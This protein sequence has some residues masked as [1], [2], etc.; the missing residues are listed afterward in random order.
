[1]VSKINKM[2]FTINQSAWNP[3]FLFLYHKDDAVTRINHRQLCLMEGK[4]NVHP[5]SDCISVLDGT[6]RA[7]K[8]PWSFPHWDSYWMCDGLIYKYVLGNSRSIS[9]RSAIFIIEYDTWWNTQSIN[10]APSLLSQYDI[11]GAEVLINGRHGW[12]FFSKHSHLSFSKDLIGIRPF[13]SICCRPKALIKAA[14]FVRDTQEMHKVYN[15]EMRFA[16][17]CKLSGSRIGN[18]P[19][20]FS[21]SIKWN[22]WNPKCGSEECIVHPV[23]RSDQL[24]I[25]ALSNHNMVHKNVKDKKLP[26]PKM[27]KIDDLSVVTAA[28]YGSLQD[29]RNACNRLRA[30]V[31]HFGLELIEF[32]GDRPKSLQD[33]KIFKLK[34][35]LEK[36]NTKWTLFIDASDVICVQNPLRAVELLRRSNKEILMSAESVCWPEDHLKDRFAK[37]QHK[38][39]E[40]YRFLNSGVFIGKT[41]HIIKHL[42]K[43]IKMISKNPS[44]NETW[45]TDQNIWQYLFLDQ[46]KNGSSISLDLDAN[47]SLSTYSIGD[48]MIVDSSRNGVK[49]PKFS[50]TGGKPLFLHFNGNDKHD[51][52]RISRHISRWLPNCQQSLIP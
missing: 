51:A 4:D 20:K 10:W 11:C 48:D 30:T 13:S 49:C 7:D 14:K 22:D 38:Q 1:M 35:D 32:Y 44:L 41:S 31:N 15:N 47:L 43:M 33:A 18:I 26:P 29:G 36:I 8:D 45:R 2:D 34:S 12:E 50:A 23:K 3:L 39:W 24:P 9:K 6:F 25:I 46:H 19:A 52:G 21:K 37:T 17:A 16:T 5:I 27:A 40:K 42:Q 28:Y